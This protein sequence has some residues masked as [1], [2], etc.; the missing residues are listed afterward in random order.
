[1]LPLVVTAVTGTLLVDNG[2]GAPISQAVSI[3]GGNASY[4]VHRTTKSGKPLW[5]DEGC[6]EMAYDTTSVTPAIA[7]VL[8]AAFATWNAATAQCGGVAFSSYRAPDLATARDGLSTVHVR[9]D[10]WC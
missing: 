2:A 4:G 1:M 3:A 10:R 9:T 6:L 7:A 8:D 5:R